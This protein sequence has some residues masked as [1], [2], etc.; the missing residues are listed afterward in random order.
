VSTLLHATVYMLLHNLLNVIVQIANKMGLK[1]QCL[2]PPVLF[3]RKS[4][5]TH[6]VDIIVRKIT[7]FLLRNPAIHPETCSRCFISRFF[8]LERHP[9]FKC[10]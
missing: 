6:G 4:M 7:S 1:A 5:G 2:L 3:Q 10:N 8:S 9:P